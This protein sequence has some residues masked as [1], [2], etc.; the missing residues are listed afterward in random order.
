[1][2]SVANRLR[3]PHCQSSQYRT[4]AYDISSKN[5]HGAKCIF[6]KSVMV[7]LT[8]PLPYQKVAA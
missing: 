1:M 2:T 3:C 7:A 5:P 8:A 6:C 4:S